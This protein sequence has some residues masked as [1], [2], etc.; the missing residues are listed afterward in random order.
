VVRFLKNIFVLVFSF[1][2]LLKGIVHPQKEKSEFTQP[3]AVPNLCDFFFFCWTQNNILKNVCNQTVNEPFFY[4]CQCGPS[5]VWLPT[6]F[7]IF[8]LCSAEERNTYTFGK[9]WGWVNYDRIFIFFF[10]QTI[11][12]KVGLCEK[13]L[14]I[15]LITFS[16]NVFLF[17]PS[18]LL[19]FK[20]MAPF[21]N[22]LQ[23]EVNAL[24]FPQIL[25]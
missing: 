2:S 12:I 15:P 9:T 21:S 23:R 8:L 24:V 7:K 13:L 10:V 17:S 14:K 18:V 19:I 6:F 11:P 25:L 16:K 3:Q 22:K 1:N 4:F 20:M 5:T